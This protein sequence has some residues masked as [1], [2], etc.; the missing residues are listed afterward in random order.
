MSDGGWRERKKIKMKGREKE[1]KR[2]QGE[3]KRKDG[4]ER[5]EETRIKQI[6]T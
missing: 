4:E 1:R 5:I 2:T 6:I 3:E